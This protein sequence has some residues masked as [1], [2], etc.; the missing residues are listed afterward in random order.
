MRALL[1][2]AVLPL[3]V[4]ALAACEPPLEEL[5]P[6]RFYTFE[7]EGI[8]YGVRAQYD[9]FER[10]WFTRVTSIE[11]PLDADDL[12]FAVAMVENQVGPLVCGGMRLDVEPGDIWND[13]AGNQVEFLEDVGAWQLVGRCS[14]EAP[15][16]V[17]VFPDAPATTVVIVD[18][19]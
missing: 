18:E 11:L 1:P 16:V 19:D 6:P 2:L 3:A 13:W 17:A 9:P 4:L 7:H 8:A 10:G 12:E 5:F 15:V 14:D